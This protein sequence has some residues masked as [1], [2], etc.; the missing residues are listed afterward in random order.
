VIVVIDYKIVDAKEKDVDILTSIKLVTMID[1]EMDKVLSPEEKS[2]VMLQ[3]LVIRNKDEITVSKYL[4]SYE[5]INVSANLGTLVTERNKR[6]CTSFI[7]TSKG[8]SA[9]IE[10]EKANVVFFSVP[11]DTG[12]NISVNDVP[13]ETIEVNYGLLGIV[14]DSGSNQIIATYHTKGLDMGICCSIICIAIWITYE[15]IF[16]KRMVGEHVSEK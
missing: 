10:L 5:I 12:W 14:C 9:E 4:P 2:I 1:D 6:T 11:Y 13:A 7:G 15:I 16:R 8:F 3:S